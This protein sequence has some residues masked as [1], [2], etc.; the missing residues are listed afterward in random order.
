MKMGLLQSGNLLNQGYQKYQLKSLLLT[1]SGLHHEFVDRYRITLSQL[2]IILVDVNT[3]IW[4]VDL[5]EVTM[6]IHDNMGWYGDV[7]SVF[8][9]KSLMQIHVVPW[10]NRN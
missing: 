2:V 7:A 1:F 4:L 5:P 9:R 10:N 6:V 3:G 8:I